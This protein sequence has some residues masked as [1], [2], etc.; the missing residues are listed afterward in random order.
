M[1]ETV[2]THHGQGDIFSGSARKYIKIIE[3]QIQENNINHF[4]KYPPV[5]ER[6]NV[7]DI[8][9]FHKKVTDGRELEY[10]NLLQ[11]IDFHC[12]LKQYIEALG[13]VEQ[14][15]QIMHNHHFLLSYNA[16]CT[17]ATT[18]I[19]D[20]VVGNAE[21]LDKI[22]LLLLKA[23]EIDENSI[24]LQNIA[25]RI[26][27]SLFD[28]IVRYSSEIRF[29]RPSFS[30]KITDFNQKE[31]RNYYEAISKFIIRL[32]DCYQIWSDTRY[33]KEF[34]LHLSG[35]KDYAWVYIDIDG[36]IH[37]NGDKIIWCGTLK[38][39]KHLEEQIKLKEPDYI[40][41]EMLYGDFF[42]EPKSI[43]IYSNRQN[44]SLVYVA[45]S[46]PFIIGVWW[47]FKDEASGF[48]ISNWR[49]IVF[50]LFFFHPVPF[51]NNQNLIQFLA[52][53]FARMLPK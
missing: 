37:D 42:E 8:E 21:S 26:S 19:K 3:R 45:L 5:T 51:F 34:V 50:C 30:I 23:K 32:E 29:S 52:R 47:V 41:P 40:L 1:T 36:N 11:R 16:L 35:H 44:N 39:I 6:L 12:D 48:L 27:E 14:A 17:Y 18:T 10:K 7:Q 33:L 13:F 46:I 4:Y 24:Y 15:S 53:L 2:N 25:P 22:K 9:D 20:L 38:K 43:I 28:L 49:V 31:Q